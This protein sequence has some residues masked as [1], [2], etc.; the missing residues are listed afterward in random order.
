MT[1]LEFL[2]FMLTVCEHTGLLRTVGFIGSVR[3][4][5]DAVTSEIGL[6]TATVIEAFDV[7]RVGTVSGD[8]RCRDVSSDSR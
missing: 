2:F 3:T 7:V 8:N 4:V 6:H 1:P 5:S